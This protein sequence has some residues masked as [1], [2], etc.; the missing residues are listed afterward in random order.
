MLPPSQWP[1]A[2]TEHLISPTGAG[3]LAPSEE[4]GTVLYTYLGPHEHQLRHTDWLNMILEMR[5]IRLLREREGEKEKASL[6]V[7]ICWFVLDSI[8][9]L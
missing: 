6:S 9:A 8:S 5:D 1:S 4:G 7:F 2:S 3:S